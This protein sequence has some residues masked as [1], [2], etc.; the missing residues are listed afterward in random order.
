MGSA[1][2]LVEPQLETSRRRL[3]K[4]VRT[5]GEAGEGRS[6]LGRGVLRTAVNTGL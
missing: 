2:G 3:R 6:L 4:T 1:A 5:Q